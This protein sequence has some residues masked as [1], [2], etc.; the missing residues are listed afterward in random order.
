MPHKDKNIYCF[1]LYRKSLP[2]SV[3]MN[4]PG[5]TGVW[6]RGGGVGRN[7][8]QKEGNEFKFG[9]KSTQIETSV[10]KMGETKTN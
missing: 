6:G 4:Q 7:M 3:A 10:K 2:T 5:K 1:A 8:F 9:H